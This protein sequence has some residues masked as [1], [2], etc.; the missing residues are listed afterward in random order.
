MTLFGETYR[1]IEVVP[2]IFDYMQPRLI[3]SYGDAGVTYKHSGIENVAQHWTTTLLKIKKKIEAVQGEYNYCIL[4]RY[5]SGSN[6]MGWHADDEPEMGNVSAYSLWKQCGRYESAT[7]HQKGED[8]SVWQS[9]AQVS[10]SADRSRELRKG[11]PQE[12][13]ADGPG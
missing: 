12:R 4:N 2:Q 9:D 10:H 13:F 1:S 5:G 7:S 8:V 11:V 3:A 6:N